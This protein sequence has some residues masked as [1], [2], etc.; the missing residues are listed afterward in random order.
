MDGCRNSI[1]LGRATR[2]TFDLLLRNSCDTHRACSNACQFKASDYHSGHTR[3]N[4]N[5]RSRHQSVPTFELHRTKRSRSFVVDAGTA[6]TTRCKAVHRGSTANASYYTQLSGMILKS[7]RTAHMDGKSFTRELQYG[8][9]PL[10]GR[11]INAST[12]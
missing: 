11:G 5:A 9:G 8:H 2:R 10:G 6:M 3:I 1:G 12:R 4:E 7:D